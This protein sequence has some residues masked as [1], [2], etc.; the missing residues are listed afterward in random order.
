MNKPMSVNEL[1]AALGQ[2][3]SMSSHNLKPLLEFN[4]ISTEAQGKKHIYFIN[5]ETIDPIFKAIENHAEKF[6]PKGGKCMIG[7]N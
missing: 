7:E 4:F 5:H 1:A 6:C 3:Q 2:E